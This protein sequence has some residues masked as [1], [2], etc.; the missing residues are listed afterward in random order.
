[1]LI[2]KFGA[3]AINEAARLRDLARV[4]KD[5]RDEGYAVVVV[6]S[7]LAGITDALI[8]AAR[9]AAEHRDGPIEYARR[10]LWGRHRALAEKLINDEWEREELYREWAELLKIFDRITRAVT[11]LGELSPRGIDAVA[12]LGER[13][14]A[15][16]VAVLLRRSG[17]A[18]K[19]VDGA[20]LI[21]TDAHF[22]NARPLLPETFMRVRAR[23]ESSLKALIVPVITGYVGAT[24]DG[25]VTTLGRGGGDYSA[26]LIGA[27]LEATEVFLWT[28]VDGILTADPK[29]VA[30][31]RTLPE[32]S[33]SEA[34]EIAA[35]GAEVLHPHT[36]AP[37]EQR[38][39][40]LH[41]RNLNHPER[42]GTRVVAR[43]QPAEQPARTIISARGLSLLSVS[44]H[45]NDADWG[46]A[47]SRMAA[48]SV[49][50]LSFTQSLSEHSL[51]LAVRAAD[52]AFARECLINAHTGDQAQVQPPEITLI[53][54]VGMVALITTPGNDALTA[55]MLTSLGRANASILTLTHA[56]THI[57]FLLPEH[58]VDTVVRALHHDLGL[59]L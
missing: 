57:S 26:T 16:L 36:L 45:S 29:I 9:A 59:A 28:D 40:P 31:A 12:V 19:M 47:L 3:A 5:G 18:S 37:L 54:P 43:P 35:L 52:A 42:T 24:R 23:L 53:S 39:I 46:P 58:Q 49:D 56:G 11:T 44:S 30:G 25:V 32:I 17:I 27:A 50:I 41:I 20:E 48:S 7:A 4:V 21:V 6:C 10:E 14:M 38:G 33:F 1:M 2:M 15:H 22:G 55:R 8:E 13:F 34:A 51:T